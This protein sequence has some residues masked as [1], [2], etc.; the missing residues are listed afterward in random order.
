MAVAVAHEVTGAGPTVVLSN[1][2]GSTRGMWDPQ[3][4]ALVAAGYRVIRYDARGHGASPVPPGPYSMDDLADDLAALLDTTG[5]ECAHVVGLSLGGMTAMRLTARHPDR[6]ASL[7]VLC[8]SALLGPPQF[9]LDRAAAVRAAGTGSI[10][11]AIVGRWFTERT[12]RA[13]PPTVAAAVAMVSSVPAE[14]YAGCCEAIAAMDLRA[15]LPGIAVPTLALA[16]AEDPATP[17]E[18]LEYIAKSIPGAALVV[19]PEAAHLANLERPDAVNAAL[20]EHLAAA[21]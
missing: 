9:W 11:E 5:T 19:V 7:A 1:S 18:H 13:D 3:V 4:P 20:L 10:A 17:P 16:G 8:T 14:G 2:V 6:V 15:D 21:R 12:R